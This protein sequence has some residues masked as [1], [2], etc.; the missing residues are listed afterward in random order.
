MVL[1]GGADKKSHLLHLATGQQTTIG[2]HDAP[3]RSVR[4]V[5]IPG[6][7]GP[8]VAS[9]SWDKTVKFWDVRQQ[10]P[11]ASL[12]CAERVYAMDSKARLLVIAT[13]ERHIHLV[14]LQNPT[15]FAR[16]LE[17]PLKFQTRAV[18]A[19]PD[20]TG[21]GTTAIEGRCG[22]NTVEEKDTAKYDYDLALPLSNHCTMAALSVY[23][24][25][26]STKF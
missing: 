24:F 5:D 9:G 25:P 8:I 10:T 13:A 20:G 11:L 21:W 23:L 14:D 7:N 12:T 19:F 1:A 4:F 6:T 2:S 26:V 3:I 22:I 15:V 17:S 18:S 16:S